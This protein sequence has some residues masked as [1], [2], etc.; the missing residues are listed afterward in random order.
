MKGLALTKKQ[1]L[2]VK[3]AN[4]I[5]ALVRLD[6]WNIEKKDKEARTPL[7]GNAITQMIRAEVVTQY[8][9]LDEILTD[10]ACRYYFKK[11]GK[12]FILWR[13]KKFRVFVNYIMDEM[14]LIKKVE[15]VHAIRPLPKG[16]RSTVHRVNSLRNALAHSFF[17]ENRKEHRKVGKVL[18]QGKDI[19]TGE[20]LEGF[21]D[22]C[23]V[24]WVYLAR[25]A[26]GSWHDD[27]EEPVALPIPTECQGS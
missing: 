15:L 1:K 25:R 19:R 3:E 2:L 24:A 7:L 16:V 13:Q 23:H 6:F 12:R 22:D 9:L 8:T 11:K 21:Q 14:F 18:Y 5:A 4:A 26:Y 20:G 10:L 27:S 17:P